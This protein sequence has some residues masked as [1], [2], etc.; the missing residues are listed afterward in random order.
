MWLL[1]GIWVS[2]M[3]I[4]NTLLCMSQEARR[5]KV[6]QERDFTGGMIP[7]VPFSYVGSTG[8]KVLDER[9]YFRTE[10]KKP[11]M[12]DNLRALFTRPGFTVE[13]LAVLRGVLRSLEKFSP[14]NPRGAG[15]PDE[16]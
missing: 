16:G 1:V 11:K 10:D 6:A 12:M 13:E 3:G 5:G 9:G 4:W 14:K 2:E 7:P 15:A 8:D